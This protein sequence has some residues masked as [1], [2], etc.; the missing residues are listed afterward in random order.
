MNWTNWLGNNKQMKMMFS[1]PPS[2][3]NVLLHEVRL[4]IDGQVMYVRFD[5][6]SFP[7]SPP[8]KWVASGFNRVQMTLGLLGISETQISG[9]SLINI[10]SI[11]FTNE[12]ETIRFLFENNESYITCA[13]RFANIVSLTGYCDS[14]KPNTLC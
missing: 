13:A 9:W 12:G 2:L 6:G 1:E 5:L 10:G 8:L 11:K 14:E 4:L 3:V 7:N